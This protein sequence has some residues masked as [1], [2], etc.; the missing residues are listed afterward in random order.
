MCH[1]HH[2]KLSRSPREPRQTENDLSSIVADACPQIRYHLR[3]ARR[4]RLA[5]RL[6]RRTSILI[7]PSAWKPE[8]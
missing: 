8:A 7:T 3:I 2:Y 6:E 5:D 4:R 1:A